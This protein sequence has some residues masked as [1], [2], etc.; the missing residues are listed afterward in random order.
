MKIMKI[1]TDLRSVSN[2]FG[3][4]N[5]DV[6]HYVI[7]F[8]VSNFVSVLPDGLQPSAHIVLSARNAVATVGLYGNIPDGI[9]SVAAD[10]FAGHC[11]T[12]D[13]SIR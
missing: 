10:I 1:R 5:E 9:L 13:I 3:S 8:F 2:L 11:N 7:I 6:I 4:W 12:Y